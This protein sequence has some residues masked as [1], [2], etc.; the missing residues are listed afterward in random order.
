MS[1][2]QY[3]RAD[4]IGLYQIRPLESLPDH[5]NALALQK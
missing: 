1:K 2:I 3:N 4:I 5:V